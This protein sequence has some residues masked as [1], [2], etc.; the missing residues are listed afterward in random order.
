MTHHDV[1]LSEAKDLFFLKT[2]TTNGCPILSALFAERVGKHKPESRMPHPGTARSRTR[3]LA[4][5]TT[6][7]LAL[8]LTP[9]THAQD[10][11]DQQNQ[12]FT[13]TVNSDLVL[14]NVIVRDKKTG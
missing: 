12:S 9:T 6:L 8:L 14:T 2:G 5:F 3:N 1:I 7:I 4:L 11:Q 10:Q 13:L